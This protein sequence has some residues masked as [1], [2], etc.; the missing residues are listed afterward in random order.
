M[1]YYPT[2]PVPPSLLPL[3]EIEHIIF[4]LWDE[5]LELSLSASPDPI[6][7]E[8]HL[9]VTAAIIEYWDEKLT[10]IRSYEVRQRRLDSGEN[11]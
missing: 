10:E 11:R 2:T 7:V 4:Q 3:H 9:D 1:T 8:Q 5:H 6:A